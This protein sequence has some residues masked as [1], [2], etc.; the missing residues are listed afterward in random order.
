MKLPVAV[1]LA[2]ATG[3]RLEWLAT[4]DGPMCP[5]EAG[6]MEAGDELAPADVSPAKPQPRP[7]PPASAAGLAEHGMAVPE[8]SLGIAWQVNPDRLARAY[9][10]ALNG[11]VTAPGRAPDPKRLMQ[12]TLIIY[13]EMTDAEAPLGPR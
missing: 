8:G 12:V 10:M 4:G 1:S 13:D 6:V 2:R 5:S 7:I 11:I 9:V 3:V